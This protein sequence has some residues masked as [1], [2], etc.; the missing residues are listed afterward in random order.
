MQIKIEKSAELFQKL[1]SL[2]DSEFIRELKQN[3]QGERN[4][5]L[6]TCHFIN[7][8][9][10][11]R[12]FPEL[13]AKNAFTY[14]TQ[15]EGFSEG[16]A[17]RR[18][19][20]ARYLRSIPHA[21]EK[22]AEGSISMDTIAMVQRAVRETEKQTGEKVSRQTKTDL[23]TQAER[24]SSVE[25]QKLVV[26]VLPHSAAQKEIIQIRNETEVR[27]HI[28]LTHAQLEKLVRLKEALSHKIIGAT[29]ADVI[30]AA[31]DELLAKKDPLKKEIKPRAV[32]NPNAA[33]ISPA[34][35]NFVMRR[36]NGEC[37]FPALDGAVC[38]SRHQV[39]IDHVVP[40]ARGGTNEAEN[41]RALCRAH[42]FQAAEQIFR[43][44][45][46]STFVRLESTKWRL[47]FLPR[48]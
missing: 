32:R 24:K 40:I 45:H 13:G 22:I 48:S 20:T 33:Q 16:A 37:Q 36:D 4:A 26:E 7:E 30:E 19:Q 38:K 27:A 25:I 44:Q 11:R 9:E 34:T 35:R 46:S 2:S 39:Q 15:I 23:L 28:R 47:T 6:R 29:L 43:K 31:A 5:I 10:R 17:N 3:M 42:N 1:E 41:L 12:C 21:A 8:L 14:L 18:I